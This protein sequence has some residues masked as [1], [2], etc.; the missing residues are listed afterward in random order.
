MNYAK[1]YDAL[2]DRA[3]CRLLE[4]YSERHHV[5][6]KCM[7]GSNNIDN[8]VR[9]TPEEH[10]VAHQLLTKIFPK[11]R[12]L[13]YAALL[14]GSSREG[15]KTYGWIK[16]RHAIAVS[17]NLTGKTKET[18]EFRKS[19]ANKLKGRSKETHDYLRKLG[20]LHR[21]RTKETCDGRRAQGTKLSGLM[22][23][24]LSEKIA[25]SL[26]GRTKETDAGIKNRA[27]KLIGRTKFTHRGVK[28]KSE[29][30]KILSKEQYLN[31]CEMRATGI[32]L[33]DIRK[34]FA[35][36][37]IKIAYSSISGMVKRTL[38]ELAEVGKIESPTLKSFSKINALS[39]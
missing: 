33:K 37:G 21:S 1:H 29:K 14:M 19:Q 32:K 36:I 35:D 17:E 31:I 6:P 3:K 11:E 9:L 24:G 10:Y 27:E 18:H 13:A 34:K 39:S 4:G 20:D 5:I 8:I 12:G 30:L 15:N 2:I 28:I 23:K 26:R 25:A 22:S 38:V 7:G 16:R